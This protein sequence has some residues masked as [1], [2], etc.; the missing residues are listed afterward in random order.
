MA[1]QR[2][3]PSEEKDYRA[4]VLSNLLQVE[5]SRLMHQ[6]LSHSRKRDDAEDALS[7]ACVQFLRFYDGTAGEAALHWMLLVIK[8]CAWA[9]GRGRVGELIEVVVPDDRLGPAELVERAEET[10]QLIE[11]IELLKPDERVALILLGL[12]C[13]YAE[14]RDLR[15]WSARKVRRCLDDGRARVR[16]MLE[17]GG[18]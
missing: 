1:T 16:K 7:D 18:T 5:H 17:E 2:Q 11:S 12:G 4:T 6:A 15:G 9:I 13:S 8:R 10:E 14:I 3:S